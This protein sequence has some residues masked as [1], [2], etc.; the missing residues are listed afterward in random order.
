[1]LT[2]Y[3]DMSDRFITV[4][5]VENDL[6]RGPYQGSYLSSIMD[7]AFD[8]CPIPYEDPLLG[9]VWCDLLDRHEE[10]RYIFGF[11]SMEQLEEWF[12][13]QET[14]DDMT[15][16]GFKV[17]VYRVNK[18]NAHIGMTQVIFRRTDSTKLVKR[19]DIPTLK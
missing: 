17:S 12:Y 14:R 16:A 7:L 8:K 4:Y 2:W 6:N 18:S 19:I 15:R 10:H 13:T 11:A 9:R 3:F 1:M 5:R